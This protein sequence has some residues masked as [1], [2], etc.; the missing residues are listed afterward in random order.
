LN[1][2][3]QSNFKTR[4]QNSFSGSVRQARKQKKWEKPIVS[5]L[6]FVF[7]INDVTE[8]WIYL[9]S[10]LFQLRRLSFVSQILLKEK[11]KTYMI[12]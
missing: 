3:E 6:E 11:E 10:F 5:L 1:L 9:L 2:F 4:I 12:T 7:E 8:L